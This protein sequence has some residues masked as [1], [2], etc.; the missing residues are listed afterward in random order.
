MRSRP[1]NRIRA[2]GYPARALVASVRTIPTAVMYTVFKANRPMGI[3]S[4]TPVKLARVGGRGMSTGGNPNTVPLA[5]SEV[6][7]SHRNGNVVTTASAAM[8]RSWAAAARRR[9]S[10]AL[11]PSAAGREYRA[12]AGLG[13]WSSVIGQPSLLEEPEVGHREQ[14]R[15]G[16]E[17]D[18]DGGGVAKV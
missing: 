11:I 18:P 5:L 17:H 3:V 13:V 16:G 10:F 12:V 6:A 7:S 4:Q 15:D 9:A 2:S 8:A 14:D 1:G